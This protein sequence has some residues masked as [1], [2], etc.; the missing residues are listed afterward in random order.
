MH[1]TKPKKLNIN[2]NESNN[3][4]LIIVIYVLISPAT[5]SMDVALCGVVSLEFP[6]RIK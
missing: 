2:Y 5:F 1:K 6:V 3:C 4:Y